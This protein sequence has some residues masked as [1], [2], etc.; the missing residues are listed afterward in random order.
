M[1]F[2]LKKYKEL[3]EVLIEKNYAFQTFEEFINNPKDKVVVLR[4]D[5]DRRSINATWLGKIEKDL[6]VKSS[7]YF[8]IVPE[9][10]DKNVIQ[11]IVSMGHEVGYHYEDLGITKGNFEKAYENYKKNL[12]YF[13]AFY[14]VTTVC[15]HGSPEN[16]IDNR[17]IWEKYNYKQDGIIAEPYFDVDYDKVFYIT[18]TGRAWNKKSVIVRDKVKTKFNIPIESIDHMMDLI[19]QDKMP[20]QLIIS[21]HPHRWFDV[22]G[23]WFKEFIMQNIKN[24]VKAILIKYRK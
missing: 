11:N 9:S 24:V 16:R 21:T 23:L 7:Y 10:N 20:D 18:D 6:N 22:G 13:R 1:D 19:R 5:V 15:M 2:T 8:R 3:L 14:P 4:H 17:Q 12:A